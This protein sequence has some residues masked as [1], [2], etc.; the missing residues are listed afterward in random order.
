MKL[1]QATTALCLYL[2]TAYAAPQGSAKNFYLVSCSDDTGNFDAIAYYPSGPSKSTT[3]W[4]PEL[5]EVSRGRSAWEGVVREAE[6]ERDNWFIATIDKGAAA[7]KSGEI[8]GTGSFEG[9]PFVCFK[10]TGL[11]FRDGSTRCE[12]RY[13]C[14][15]VDVGGGR[16]VRM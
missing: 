6:F 3:T 10:Q 2:S 8:A 7:L 12:K 9:E 5:S 16:G 4:P 15:S 14:P 1:S 11:L 13:W